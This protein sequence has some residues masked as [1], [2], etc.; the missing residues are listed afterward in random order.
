VAWI[1]GRLDPHGEV[2]VVDGERG[3]LDQSIS[4]W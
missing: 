3:E 4:A 2:G 1:R